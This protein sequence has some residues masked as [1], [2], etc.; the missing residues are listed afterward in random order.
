MQEPQLKEEEEE[1]ENTLSRLK[2]SSN[3]NGNI[4]SSFTKKRPFDGETIERKKRGYKNHSQQSD[5]SRTTDTED[6]VPP[7]FPCS[8]A[9]SVLQKDCEEDDNVNLPAE[10]IKDQLIIHL[11][12]EVEHMRRM[13]SLMQQKIQ[14]L[15]QLANFT[16]SL[17]NPC[18]KRKKQRRYG[19]SSM[20]QDDDWSPSPVN[21]N[22]R[23]SLLRSPSLALHSLEDADALYQGKQEEV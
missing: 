13:A 17:D 18:K 15:E 1:E 11:R 21:S 3:N 2:N 22:K 12:E 10:K 5:E 16:T 6:L 23:S 14:V 4:S 9:L 8:T 19:S 20:D 7:S